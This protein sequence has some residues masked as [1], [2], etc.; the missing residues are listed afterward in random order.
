LNQRNKDG[1]LRS[2][3]KKRGDLRK[4]GKPP[5]KSVGTFG[6]LERKKR[7]RGGKMVRRGVQ[8]AGPG[9]GIRLT[10]KTGRVQ[11]GRRRG[12]NRPRRVQWKGLHHGCAKTQ[13]RAGPLTTQEKTSEEQKRKT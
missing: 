1:R 10:K 9:G 2:S 7:V 6:Q 12:R 3:S 11:G 4:K 8:E 5:E 13:T